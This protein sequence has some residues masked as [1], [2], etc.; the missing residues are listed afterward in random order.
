MIVTRPA[1]PGASQE[2]YRV[3]LSSFEGPLDLLLFLIR[4]AEVDVQDIP[5]AQITDQYLAFLGGLD[6]IDI[7]LAGEF[8]L[9][10]ATL[11]E[12]KSRTLAPQPS[13]GEPEGAVPVDEAAS[14]PRGELIRQL[15]AY[16]RY[17]AAAEQLERIRGDFAARHAARVAAGESGPPAE[18]EVELELE[19]AHVADLLDAYERIVAAIDFT[20]IGEHAVEYDDTPISLH[21]EDL[22]DRLARVPAR[23]Q[24]LVELIRGRTRGETI[25]LFLATLELL[26]QRKVTLREAAGEDESRLE[27]E[28]NLEDAGTAAGTPGEAL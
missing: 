16:Q 13:G 24:C 1:D 22:L 3:R 4:R 6:R 17:R 8:L 20:R 2:D 19:D 23:R 26:R 14:D 10:A 9:M 27:I 18:D 25:G 5:I 12:I 21:Q 28:L 11:V 15:L 7:D